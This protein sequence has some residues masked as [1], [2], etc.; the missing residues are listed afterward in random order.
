H[1]PTRSVR[2]RALRRHGGAERPEDAAPYLSVLS[3]LVLVIVQRSPRL[4]C[5]FRL[6]I[7]LAGG[8]A[9]IEAEGREP[10]L[11]LAHNVRV[12][13]EDVFRIIAVQRGHVID[14][15][16]ADQLVERTRMIVAAAVDP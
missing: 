4:E 6:R 10:G 9:A 1:L 13:R 5:G 14:A 11:D 16:D 2:S 15:D 3:D 8:S 7:E 12:H